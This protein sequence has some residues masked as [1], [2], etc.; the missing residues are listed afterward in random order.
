MSAGRLMLKAA[1][2]SSTVK[3]SFTIFNMTVVGALRSWVCGVHPLTGEVATFVG[4]FSR[5]ANW[6]TLRGLKGNGPPT[7]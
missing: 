7:S 6:Y 2:I 1:A 4:R 5:A 3:S